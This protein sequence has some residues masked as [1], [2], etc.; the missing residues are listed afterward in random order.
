MNKESFIAFT[1]FFSFREK[2]AKKTLHHIVISKLSRNDG[3]YSF[4]HLLT[5]V[6]LVEDKIPF[7]WYHSTENGR[8]RRLQIIFI[9]AH[10][11]GHSVFGRLSR[12]F[13][14]LLGSSEN[15]RD[16][17]LRKLSA[18]EAG[19][20]VKDRREHC[21]VNENAFKTFEKT[22]SLCR[23]LFSWDLA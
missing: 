18:P 3:A 10:T 23:F 13:C 21:F 11:F 19:R 20:L 2:F 22:M 7:F 4:G 9:K 8:L 1:A 12:D 14:I 16:P 5:T 17:S 15:G 6:E